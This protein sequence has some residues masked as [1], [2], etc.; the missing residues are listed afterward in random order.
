MHDQT[1]QALRTAIFLL[2]CATS[3][4]PGESPAGLRVVF[5]PEGFVTLAPEIPPA[6]EMFLVERSTDLAKW[7]PAMPARLCLADDPAITLPAT[8]KKQFYRLV[9]N[10]APDAAMIPVAYNSLGPAFLLGKYEVTVG[11]WNAVVASAAARGYDLSPR[12]G[13]PHPDLPMLADWFD[14]MKWCNLRSEL[15][16]LPLAYL[17]GGNPY[18]TG[19]TV[20]TPDMRAKG[21]RLPY[22][23]EWDY[24]LRG[25]LAGQGF[26]YSGSNDIDEV[27]WYLSNSEGGPAPDSSGLGPRPVGWKKANELGFHDMNGNQWEWIWDIWPYSEGKRY[28]RGGYYGTHK[29]ICTCGARGGAP[30][31]I[32]LGFRIARNP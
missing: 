15:A 5:E 27:A 23:H 24:A 28:M 18:R 31:E 7:E 2:F 21:Y 25:G 22:N 30:P 17:I 16:G 13:S 11:E 4:L 12:T 3:P 32:T 10:P 26:A 9:T 6:G 8:G 29:S 1:T 19:K 20:P 14:A